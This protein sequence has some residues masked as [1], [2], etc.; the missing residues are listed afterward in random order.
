MATPLEALRIKYHL[1][2]ADLLNSLINRGGEPISERTLRGLLS[3][4]SQLSETTIEENAKNLAETIHCI[5]SKLDQVELNRECRAVLLSPRGSF[6]ADEEGDT[7]GP[8]R[9]GWSHYVRTLQLKGDHDNLT[10]ARKLSDSLQ[11]IWSAYQE[12]LYPGRIGGG[13]RVHS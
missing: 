13:G 2:R 5:N 1:T 7:R 9:A 12:T 11:G 6:Q 8:G 4:Q 3:G 10:K